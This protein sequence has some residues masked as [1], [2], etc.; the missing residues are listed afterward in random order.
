[1]VLGY[2]NKQISEAL[3]ISPDT[4]KSHVSSIMDKICSQSRSDTVM[5]LVVFG[6]VPLPRFNKRTKQL[7]L[8]RAR[9]RS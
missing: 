7:V 6:M 5:R 8:G 4:V 2:S 9:R 1:M 3:E